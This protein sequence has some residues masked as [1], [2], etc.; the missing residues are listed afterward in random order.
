MRQFF[1]FGNSVLLLCRRF[2]DIEFRAKQV[3]YQWRYSYLQTSHQGSSILSSDSRTD[4]SHNSLQI[5][6]IC[7]SGAPCI[8]PYEV[9]L[10]NPT[11]PYLHTM[12]TTNI[13]SGI[14]NHN[15]C[16]RQYTV[17]HGIYSQLNGLFKSSAAGKSPAP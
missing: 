15:P 5:L 6:L 3:L 11:G 2:S 17:Q 4:S 14:R 16:S 1:G 7:M 13:P 9:A 10:S 8:A 12:Q